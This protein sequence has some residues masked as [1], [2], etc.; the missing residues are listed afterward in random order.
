MENKPWIE[1]AAEQMAALYD[2]NFSGKDG[3]RYRIS[4]K[5]VREIGGRKRL[6]EGDVRDL[7]RGLFE[8]GYV[9]IDMDTFFV[10]MSSNAF[11]NYRRANEDCVRS[12]K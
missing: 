11:V 9:L 5:L 4:V 12:A 1:T 3:G 10:V 8:L 6:Y 7:S 2:E